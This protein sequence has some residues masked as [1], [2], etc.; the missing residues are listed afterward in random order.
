MRAHDIHLVD[1]H[2]YRLQEDI[3]SVSLSKKKCLQSALVITKRSPSA[4]QIPTVAS[5]GNHSDPHSEKGPTGQHLRAFPAGLRGRSG[6]LGGYWS[7]LL[8]L[9]LTLRDEGGEG[10]WGTDVYQAR[11]ICRGMWVSLAKWRRWWNTLRNISFAKEME[12]ES[13]QGEGVMGPTWWEDLRTIDPWISLLI[14]GE[15]QDVLVLMVYIIITLMTDSVLSTITSS[16]QLADRISGN[17]FWT[18]SYFE[19][20]QYRGT[21]R[22]G[23]RL[24]HH[25]RVLRRGDTAYIIWSRMFQKEME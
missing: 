11:N 5:Q 4:P 17:T 14:L 12:T 18:L 16:T 22:W 19:T 13:N 7:I 9:I 8:G 6:L 15:T 21:L 3:T 24:L 25:L 2:D 1:S 10:G 20:A 23:C